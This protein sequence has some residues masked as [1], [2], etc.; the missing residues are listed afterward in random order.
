MDRQKKGRR[1]LSPRS[2][3]KIYYT[4]VAFRQQKYLVGIHVLEHFVGDTCGSG[5]TI[6]LSLSQS[7]CAAVFFQTINVIA[8]YTFVMFVSDLRYN[9]KFKKKIY[10]C[11]PGTAPS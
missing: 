5:Q 8:V 11:V 7:L 3:N 4:G 6:P 1:Q 9:R 10:V 2:G